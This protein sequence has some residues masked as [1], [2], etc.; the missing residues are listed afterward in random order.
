VPRNPSATRT[1][2]GYLVSGQWCF[3]SGVDH[4]AWIMIPASTDG[5]V[6]NMRF[7]LLPRE[8]VTIKDDWHVA[9][10]SGTGS[11]SILLDNAEI[12][13]HRTLLIQD[14]FAARS[15]AES[16]NTGSVFRA[17]FHMFAGSAMLGP[18]VGAA[19]GAC[20]Q[21]LRLCQEYPE[22]MDIEDTAV[23]LRI[24]ESSA[25]I[26]TAVYLLERI[27]ETQN[28]YADRNLTA[29]MND[30]IAMLRDRTYATRLCVRG[31]ERLVNG[32][33]AS[34][35]LDDQPIQRQYRDLTAMAQQIGVNWDRNMSSCGQ[36]LLGLR[37][38][39]AFLNVE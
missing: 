20:R 33:S 37:T 3:C 29:R 14:F 7:C 35:I 38:N 5:T 8:D 27:L 24:A 36:K 11:K 31:V 22:E 9:G 32:L 28:Y 30:R 10:M 18:I 13:Q 39:E 1:D 19:E 15:E 6:E 25:E 16:V 4:A 21:M 12:P 17:D 23:Q 2:H 34:S 26:E